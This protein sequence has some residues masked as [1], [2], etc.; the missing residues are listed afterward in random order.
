MAVGPDSGQI[1]LFGRTL[2]RLRKERGLQPAELAARVGIQT[3]DLVRMEKG[4]FR[5]A[6][7]T[8]ASIA[9]ELGVGL[10]ELV[11]DAEREPRRARRERKTKRQGDEHEIEEFVAFRHSVS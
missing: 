8:L 3:A 10:P 9:R 2:R 1:E 6:L 5:I 4:G 11:A 7:D